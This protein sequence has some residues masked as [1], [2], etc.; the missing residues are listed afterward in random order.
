MWHAY[1][2]KNAFS[3]DT[4]V[5]NIVSLMLTFVLKIAFSN[6]VDTRGTM[7]HKHMYSWNYGIQGHL[8]SVCLWKNFILAITF[9]Q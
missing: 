6:F 7:F 4:K 8:V 9:D 2:T 3:N 5:K 1:S